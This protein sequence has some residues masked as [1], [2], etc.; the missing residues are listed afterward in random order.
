MTHSAMDTAERLFNC[1]E[2]GDVDALAA[3]YADDIAVW[4]N[5]SRSEQTKQQNLKTLEELTRAV[6]DIRYEILERHDLGGRVVQRHNLRFTA[7]NGER[8]IIPACIFITVEGGLVRRIDEYLDTGQV[9]RA[10]D[11]Q[12]RPRLSSG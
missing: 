4:H 12:G 11:A 1:V 10:R 2:A 8:F 5:F 9:N 3:L 7:P 6:S